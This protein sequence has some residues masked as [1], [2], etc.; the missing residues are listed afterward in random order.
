MRLIGRTPDDGHI[1][2]MSMSEARTLKEALEVI[3][4]ILTM[5]DHVQVPAHPPAPVTTGAGRRKKAR[6]VTPSRTDSQSAKSGGGPVPVDSRQCQGCGKSFV[7][8]R[9]D[10]RCCTKECRKLIPSKG[11]VKG[12]A[13]IF[14]KRAGRMD[15]EATGAVV[16]GVC[17]DSFQPGRPGATVCPTCVRKD[18]IRKADAKATAKLGIARKSRGFHDGPESGIAP[19]EGTAEFEAAQRAAGSDRG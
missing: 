5:D 2:A 16:C 19:A 13:V 4:T 12:P 11:R 1:L 18:L 14:R 15:L 3:D 9:K 17:R 6:R 7:P 8:R 10:Q